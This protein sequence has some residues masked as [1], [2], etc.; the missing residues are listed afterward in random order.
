MFKRFIHLTTI[1]ILMLA[2]SVSFAWMMDVTS[3]TGYY[4][5]LRFEDPTDDNPNNDRIYIASSDISV[6]LSVE[7]EDGYIPIISSN[8]V[9]NDMYTSSNL[10]PG[11]VTKYQLKIKNNTNAEMNLSVI[12][13]DILASVTEFYDSILIGT[14]YTEGFYGQYETP[15]VNE[16]KLSEN[17]HENGEG[18][19]TRNFIEYFKIPGNYSEVEIRF[20]VKIDHNGGNKLQDQNFKI[21]KINFVII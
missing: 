18:T 20:Y 16:C 21:G 7:S 4:P 12:F 1:I 6:D 2:I 5:V 13:T 9:K 3:P 10:G 11:S 17:M 19:Y 14:F 15:W 8:N